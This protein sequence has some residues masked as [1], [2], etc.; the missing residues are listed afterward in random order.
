MS[1]T[2]V[3]SLDSVLVAIVDAVTD[4]DSCHGYKMRGEGV[5]MLQQG[6]VREFVEQYGTHYIR[7]K[8]GI[9]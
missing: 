4:T 8:V 3:T 9:G 2:E 6:D 5:T 7:K 1:H